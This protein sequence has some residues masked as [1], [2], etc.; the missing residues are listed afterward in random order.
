MV[1]FVHAIFDY[2]REMGVMVMID[3]QPPELRCIG[4]MDLV[5]A[6]VRLGQYF[7]RT[8][9]WIIFASPI[10]GKK[11]LWRFARQLSFFIILM[12]ITSPLIFPRCGSLRF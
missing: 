2:G 4:T 3:M 11:R 6:T 7:R 5:L 10:F 1:D 12:V 9:L 8:C